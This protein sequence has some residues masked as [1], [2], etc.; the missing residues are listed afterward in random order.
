[1]LLCGLSWVAR[2]GRLERGIVVDLLKM[3]WNLQP[4]AE[5]ARFHTKARR[6]PVGRVQAAMSEITE[7]WAIGFVELGEALKENHSTVE[8]VWGFSE[9]LR[10]ESCFRVIMTE[11]ENC[12]WRAV[13]H[14]VFVVGVK[15]KHVTGLDSTKTSCPFYLYLNQKLKGSPWAKFCQNQSSSFVQTK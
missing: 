4:C 12:H 9:V 15:C 13:S 6:Q 8:S 3:W 2:S 10:W 11:R 7:D 1:M 14:S 5:S